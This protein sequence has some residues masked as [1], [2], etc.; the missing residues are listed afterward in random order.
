[1]AEEVKKRKIFQVAKEL[2]VASPVIIEYLEGLGFDLPKT[3]KHMCLVTDEM[4]EEAVKRFDKLRWQ[5]QQET[6]VREAEDTRRREAEKAREEQLRRILDESTAP[7]IEAAEFIQEI[8]AR[9]QE[10]EEKKRKRR[11][12]IVRPEAPPVVPEAVQPEIVPQLPPPAE[13]APPE[14]KEV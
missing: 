4:Y 2:N 12:K 8:E 10:Q 5:Q 7:V 6:L 13:P 14:V 11:A 1:M 3:P 9:K